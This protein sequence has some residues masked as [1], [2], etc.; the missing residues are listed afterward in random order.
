MWRDS[1]ACS[2]LGGWTVLQPAHCARVARR[3]HHL[4]QAPLSSLVGGAAQF[5]RIVGRACRPGRHDRG[6]GY[7]YG[8]H[9]DES[10]L[11]PFGKVGRARR[12]RARVR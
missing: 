3:F 7:G 12:D 4:G 1:L 5:G 10:Q 11:Q 2:A 8:V 6:Y 9:E